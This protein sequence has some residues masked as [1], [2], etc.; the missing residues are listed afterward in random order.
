MYNRK[1]GYA[2]FWLYFIGTQV[3][4][5]PMH[6]LGLAGMPRRIGSYLPQFQFWNDVAT[7]GAYILGFGTLVI[8]LNLFVSAKVGQKVSSNPWEA[9]TLEWLTSSPPPEHNFDQIPVVTESPY[10]PYKS[11]ELSPA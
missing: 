9:Q 6:F 1:L 10:G 5:F 2:G 11:P 3:T 7:I 4:F 8:V